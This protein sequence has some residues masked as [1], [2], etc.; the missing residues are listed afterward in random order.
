MPISTEY[1][2]DDEG[3]NL[4]SAEEHAR[5]EQHADKMGDHDFEDWA[6]ATQE[7]RVLSEDDAARAGHAP[8]TY[9]R[10]EW[11]QAAKRTHEMSSEEY[12]DWNRA[13]DEGRVS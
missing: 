9:T 12:D 11:E 2:T 4:Y 3:R 7:G 10:E 6:T 5:L 8:R 13:P 1:G